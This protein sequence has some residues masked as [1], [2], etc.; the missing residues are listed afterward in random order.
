MRTPVATVTIRSDGFGG[1]VG[2]GYDIRLGDNFSLTPFGNL[3][4]GGFEDDSI[5]IVVQL[6]LGVTWH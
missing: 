5:I 1:T 4:F 6:G 2:A 3:L